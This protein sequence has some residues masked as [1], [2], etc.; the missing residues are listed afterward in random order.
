MEN[1]RIGLF[2]DNELNIIIVPVLFSSEGVPYFSSSFYQLKQGWTNLELGN[3]IINA[4]KTSED[5]IQED[6]DGMHYWEKATR[7]KSFK[8]FSKQFRFVYINSIPS[9]SLYSIGI[10]KRHAKGY[11]YIESDEVEKRIKT[12]HGIPSVD[13]IAEYVLKALE[14]GLYYD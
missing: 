2:I 8:S 9:S 5:N 13:T 11:Y 6:R 1:V 4:L 7:F 3:A 12:Y 10:Q 14:I